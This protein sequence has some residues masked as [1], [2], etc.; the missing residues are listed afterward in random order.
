MWSPHLGM[1]SCFPSLEPTSCLT[2]ALSSVTTWRQPPHLHKAFRLPRHSLALLPCPPSPALW[3]MWDPV[4]AV[5]RTAV[6]SPLQVGAISHSCY[7]DGAGDEKANG[8]Y[9]THN[10]QSSDTRLVKI[11]CC[12]CCYHHYDYMS[13]ERKAKNGVQSLTAWIKSICIHNLRVVSVLRT[14][15]GTTEDLQ[16]EPQITRV[17]YRPH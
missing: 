9:L 11:C 6:R 13:V 4:L 2:R 17:C 7:A 8:V 5:A 14:Q 10:T 1:H 16:Q 3:Q 12:C 15:A